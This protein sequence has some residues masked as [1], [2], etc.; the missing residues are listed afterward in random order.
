MS[1]ISKV[2]IK[3]SVSAVLSNGVLVSTNPKNEFCVSVDG[4]TLTV[5]SPESISCSTSQISKGIFGSFQ[6]IFNSTIVIGNTVEGKDIVESKTECE[7]KVLKV[8]IPFDIES[9][10]ISGSANINILDKLS[11]LEKIVVKGSAK[12]KYLNINEIINF[13][14]NLVTLHCSGSSSVKISG[15]TLNDLFV[16]VSGSA[17]V[18]LNSYKCLGELS[19]NASG[20]SKVKISGEQKSLFKKTSG[21]ASIS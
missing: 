18:K 1:K 4:E 7:N 20:A 9:L 19:I 16:A 2:I 15:F 3:G 8:D 17:L 12:L 6:N 5:S 11:E 13:N 10:K 14:K 21:A